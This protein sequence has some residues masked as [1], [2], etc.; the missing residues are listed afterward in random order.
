M[1]HSQ[2]AIKKFLALTTIILLVSVSNGL[3]VVNAFPNKATNYLVLRHPRVA[4]A[5]LDDCLRS[6]PGWSY[7]TGKIYDVNQMLQTQNG[8]NKIL[9]IA[10][11]ISKHCWKEAWCDD[12]TQF[13][14]KHD[15]ELSEFET[16]ILFEAA[17]LENTPSNLP[18]YEQQAHDFARL[19]KAVSYGEAF[20]TAYTDK[21][22][23]Q[24]IN[25]GLSTLNIRKSWVETQ[26]WPNW[27]ELQQENVY[28]IL[29]NDNPSE[30]DDTK[31]T[32]GLGI[33]QVTANRYYIKQALSC[34]SNHVACNEVKA[35]DGTSMPTGMSE[36]QGGTRPGTFNDTLKTYWEEIKR[37]RC[38]I[39]QDGY[40]VDTV[41]MDISKAIRD[42][43]YNI[44]KGAEL[45]RWKQFVYAGPPHY[46]VVITFGLDITKPIYDKNNY[47]V[48]HE[49]IPGLNPT[50]PNNDFD[51]ALLASYYK[52][53]HHPGIGE[54]QWE[55]IF[56]NMVKDGRNYVV[57]ESNQIYYPQD[58]NNLDQTTFCYLYKAS[59]YK[60][61]LALPWEANPYL[62]AQQFTNNDKTIPP[63]SQI[64]L[65][66]R[67]P[68]ALRGSNT[69]PET[70]ITW[71]FTHAQFLSIVL[72]TKADGSWFEVPPSIPV[73]NISEYT[74]RITNIP[75]DSEYCYRAQLHAG[76]LSSE[77]SDEVCFT[78]PPSS[79]YPY[80]IQAV[81]T[82]PDTISPLKDL[83]G[84]FD[85]DAREG[86]FA[87]INY[88]PVPVSVVITFTKP[89]TL[90]GF[91]STVGG[92]HGAPNENYW[93]IE[94][95][96]NGD[97][98][99]R[100]L[101]QNVPTDTGA[102]RIQLPAPHTAKVFK[103]TTRRNNGDGA[104]H[105][106]ELTPLFAS[107]TGGGS[108]AGNV[109]NGSNG[110]KTPL[111]GAYIQ[112]CQIGGFCT[113][114]IS[115]SDGKYA[116]NQL[117]S[118]QYFVTAFP[119]AGSTLLK[120]M[121]G[122][123]TLASSATLS[124]QDIVLLGPNT[125]PAGTSITSRNTTSGGLPIVYW[126]EA[127]TLTTQGC[128]GGS[129][130]YTISQNGIV[131]RSGFLQELS[132]TGVYRT[133]MAQLYPIHD[134]ARVSIEIA[135]PDGTTINIVFDIYI[136]PSGWVRTVNGTPITDA[137]VTLYRSDTPEGPFTLVPD[138]SGLMSPM[139]RRNP[140]T[141]D[142]NGHFG[143]D[144]IAGYYQVRAAREGCVSPINADQPYVESE[145]LTIPP[146]VLNLDLRLECDTTP[147]V[148]TI[149][150]P[151][152]QP[153]LHTVSLNVNW[154]ATD[155]GSG[156]ASSN[157][158]L[159]GSVVTNGQSVD[160]LFLNLGSHTMTVNATDRAGNAASASVIFT[161]VADI[162]SLI[163]LEQRAC[164]LGWINGNGVCNS[165]EVKLQAAKKSIDGGKF[166]TAKNQLNAFMAELDAQNGKKVTQGFDLLKNDTAY[167]I[168]K[169]P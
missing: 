114:T 115:A 157:A 82:I 153:Y 123:L 7:C 66:C 89:V 63:F 164:S 162:N 119:P 99:Y 62:P 40:L 67:R 159:D 154:S 69:E 77:Y 158:A 30:E 75:A 144:V 43:Y 52:T 64:N 37:V 97:G 86:P 104:V 51:L 42:P 55:A 9:S 93:T 38:T 47:V 58:E 130:S 103:V 14:D 41:A 129:A 56:L 112:V 74:Y 124:G 95:D 49:A 73:A 35:S 111:N 156:V 145:V 1:L 27:S 143:W 160:L 135:C 163:A 48:G 155:T 140:D 118:G 128:T 11:L 106:S 167:V 98:N 142:S 18:N 125:P 60:N 100:T 70:T 34:K 147:P 22:P 15:H 166:N 33:M 79:G 36:V 39:A 71:G 17:G 59:I 120:K 29:G 121:I 116:A 132:G 113:G 84:L 165:L 136:D 85:G 161:V 61:N 88:S 94:A 57:Q 150:G 105:M 13:S 28:P 20:A 65:I 137:T 83:P 107:A 117:E 101:V 96:D 110:I 138:D 78:T 2:F 4:E 169:L 80:S 5:N 108:I 26:L 6:N 76:V 12:P 32:L 126:G 19:L 102:I 141:T 16:Q 72:K 146:E 122:P 10:T 68:P 92:F 45:I 24:F 54:H 3:S 168:S 46:K 91:D 133:S 127:L 21:L 8:R 90:S 44:C 134:T 139:N 149:T 25:Q 87:L 131:K 23:R 81:S 53:A 148:I 151:L 50:W 152:A 109:Y 31:T